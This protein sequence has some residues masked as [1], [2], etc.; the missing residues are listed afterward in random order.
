MP[1]RPS[2]YEVGCSRHFGRWSGNSSFATKLGSTG[3]RKRI[4]DWFG[5]SLR[6]LWMEDPL[7]VP[8]RWPGVVIMVCVLFL[9]LCCYEL[10]RRAT[11]LGAQ[12]AAVSWGRLWLRAFDASLNWSCALEES[13]NYGRVYW[14]NVSV[15]E[16]KRMDSG[17]RE[18]AQR[19]Q[20]GFIIPNPLHF[21]R[22]TEGLK[23][24]TTVDEEIKTCW[25]LLPT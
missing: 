14:G 16:R 15:L 6:K 5:R 20:A 9:L 2:R 8:R 23:G 17:V 13:D 10:R 25:C 12:A 22:G 11:R 24:C 18:G 3:R 7:G 4:Q 1:R 21:L 19:R